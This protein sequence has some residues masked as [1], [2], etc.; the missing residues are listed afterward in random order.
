M[1]HSFFQRLSFRKGMVL[2]QQERHVLNKFIVRTMLAHVRQERLVGSSHKFN[3][4]VAAAPRAE[5][6]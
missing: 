6:P 2:S 4:I 1:L 5:S 3:V